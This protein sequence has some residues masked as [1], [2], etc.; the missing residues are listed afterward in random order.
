M[1]GSGS[2]L[3]CP[4]HQRQLP[5][6]VRWPRRGALLADPRPLFFTLCFLLSVPLFLIL[7][8][9]SLI[10]IF[11]LLSILCSLRSDSFSNSL[12]LLLVPFSLLTPPYSLLCCILPT[13]CSLFPAPCSLLSTLCSSLLAGRCRLLA[14]GAGVA[15]YLLGLVCVWDGARWRRQ[16]RLPA[17]VNI[18]ARSPPGRAR[19]GASLPRAPSAGRC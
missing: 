18:R 1:A 3:P 8:P 13:P 10:H 11:S 19:R 5:V 9:L 2:S 6:G 4:C 17:A 16:T 14:A 15:R 7:A 12:F